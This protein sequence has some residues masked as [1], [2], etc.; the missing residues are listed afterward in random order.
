M[1]KFEFY[2]NA[3]GNVCIRIESVIDEPYTAIKEL[4]EEQ[5]KF[6]NNITSNWL[7]ENENK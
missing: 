2:V 7:L 3:D 1:N 4:S 6:I 5:I